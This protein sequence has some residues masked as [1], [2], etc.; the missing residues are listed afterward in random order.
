MMRRASLL[1]IGRASVP[2]VVIDNFWGDT[3]PI[4]ELAAALAPFPPA[5]N[6][7]PGVRRVITSG[8]RVAYAYIDSVLECAAPY[9]CQAFAMES[10][11]IG[12]ASF[13]MITTPPGDL[14]MPQRAPHFDSL[15][16]QYLAVLHYL[17]PTAGTA[18]YRHRETGIEEVTAA[19]LNAYVATAKAQAAATPPGYILDTNAYYER[20]GALE[21]LRDRL[22]I[23]PGRL[24]HSALITPDVPL[25]DNPRTGRITSNIFIK[26]K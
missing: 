19:N 17:V 7:Y 3:A 11:Q 18:F 22:V 20:I 8:D 2:V 4:L 24:L 6:N 5:T 10:F 21:G 25:N 23:Y 12:E 26:N 14:A 9:I 1:H 15:E 13:S 16:N